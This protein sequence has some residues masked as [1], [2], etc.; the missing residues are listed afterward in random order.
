MINIIPLLPQ[1]ATIGQDI[2]KCIEG[3]CT[4]DEWDKTV[5]DVYKMAVSIPEVQSVVVLMQITSYVA[6]VSFP[7]IE[8]FINGSSTNDTKKMKSVRN[9][10]SKSVSNQDIAQ[11]QRTVAFFDEVTAKIAKKNKV[12]IQ[13]PDTSWTGTFFDEVK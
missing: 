1:M 9:K 3:G 10:V 12:K 11:A 5:D 6:K 13:Q 8:G 4:K 2:V 7:L